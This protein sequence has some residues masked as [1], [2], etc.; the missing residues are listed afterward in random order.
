MTALAKF[1][2]GPLDGQELEASGRTMEYR[3]GR[4]NHLYLKADDEPVYTWDGPYG[5][6]TDCWSAET[7]EHERGEYCPACGFVEPKRT[8]RRCERPMQ[9]VH[10]GASR[11]YWECTNPACHAMEVMPLR[12][13]VCGS[14]DVAESPALRFRCAAGHD[15]H[16]NRGLDQSV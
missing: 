2:G 8:C 5:A 7:I 4:L 16:F 13:P 11:G 12:C 10:E 15:F 9:W 1:G 14:R 6:C 3:I